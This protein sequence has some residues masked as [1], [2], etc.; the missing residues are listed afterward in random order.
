MYSKVNGSILIISHQERILNIADQIIVIEDGKV[1]QIGKKD[2]VWP[3][4]M[5]SSA[6]SV[7]MENN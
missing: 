3:Q 5:G 7:L 4:L 2:D 1:K 6:C